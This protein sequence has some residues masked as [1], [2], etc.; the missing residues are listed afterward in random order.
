MLVVEN[1]TVDDNMHFLKFFNLQFSENRKKSWVWKYFIRMS[2]IIYRCKIC[3]AVLS[4]KGCNTNNMNRHVRTK[5]PT[6]YQLEMDEKR[7]AEHETPV[8]TD[9]SHIEDYAIERELD[10]SHGKDF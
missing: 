9:T 10:I 6:V 4:I 3:E 7:Q 2:S 8:E 5:H 1:F